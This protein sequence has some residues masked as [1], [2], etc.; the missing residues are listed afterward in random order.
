MNAA[1]LRRSADADE[2][3]LAAGVHPFSPYLT[4]DD[5]RDIARDLRG[6]ADELEYRAGGPPE[7]RSWALW[8]RTAKYDW[9]EHGRYRTRDEAL[10]DADIDGWPLASHPV[11]WAILPSGERPGPDTRAAVSI[12]ARGAS[13]AE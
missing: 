12:D 10:D 3:R 5:I 4:D 2:A 13:D 1:A 9:A 6:Y 7:E 11:R 8:L